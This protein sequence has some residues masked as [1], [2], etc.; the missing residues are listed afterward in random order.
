MNYQLHTIPIV[1]Y[2]ICDDDEGLHEA[3]NPQDLYESAA[4]LER[5]R[6]DKPSTLFTLCAEVAA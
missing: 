1:K 3:D 6:D 2:F 4:L 5:L